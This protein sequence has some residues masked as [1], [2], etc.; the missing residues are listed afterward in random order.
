MLNASPT[1]N[2]SPKLNANKKVY[3]LGENIYSVYNNKH[4]RLVCQTEP[5]NCHSPTSTQYEV[6]V[7]I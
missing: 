2:A 3:A 4:Y 7:T 1:L 6:G 5:G